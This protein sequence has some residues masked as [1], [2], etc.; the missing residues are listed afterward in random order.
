M[1]NRRTNQTRRSLLLVVLVLAM[2]FATV[3]VH[4]ATQT[5]RKKVAVVLSG[6]GA[7]G[8][9]HIGVLRVLERAGIPVDIVTGTS[10]G[11]IVGGLY[12]IGYDANHIDSLV[13]QQDWKFLLS[14][15]AEAHSPL[16]YNRER[17][18]TYLA[19]KLF[20]FQ[21]KKITSDIG[22]V[23]EGRNLGLLFNRLTAAYPD[24][25]DF[26]LLPRPFACVAT[27][28][29][30]NTE[31]VFHSGRLAEAMRSSM[32]IPGVFSPIRK[33]DRV[34]VDGGL[35]NNFP[36]DVA[37][38]MGADVVIGVT[39]Q[40][41]PKTADDIRGAADVL[42][43]IVDVNC[44]NKYDDNLAMTDVAIR[45]NTKG[46]SSA[47]FTPVA[48]DSLIRRGET[49]ALLKW[50]DIVALRQKIGID[51]TFVPEK[52]TLKV[53]VTSADSLSTTSETTHPNMVLASLG[54]RF[55]TE[56][57]VAV[58]LNGYYT[59]KNSLWNLG[60]TLRLGKRI[61]ARGDVEY[62]P[63]KKGGMRF[64]YIFRR[65]DINLYNEG[66][67][68][69]NVLYNQHTIDLAPFNFDIRN[70]AV[71]IGARFDYYSYE[72]FLSNNYRNNVELTDSHERLI[73]YYATVNYNSENKWLFPTR[74]ARFSARY[75]YN[76]DDFVKYNDK[77]GFSEIAASWR[78]AVPINSRLTLQPMV[79]GRLM[80][81]SEIPACS[82]NV[83]GGNTFSHYIEQQMPFA[84]VG[85]AEYV[86]KFTT[87]LQLLTYQRIADNNYISWNVSAFGNSD[88]LR[89]VYTSMPYFGFQLGYTY[90]SMF[91][92][93][94]ASV[95]WSTLT[96][97]PNLYI[98]LGFDF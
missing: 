70:F 98:S 77:N 80:F 68:A 59:P 20:T 33:G 9:A 66:D 39:V 76:T 48:I 44:K 29:I 10:M 4:A 79:Y 46:Y 73:A 81:G 31:Y 15:K 84:G 56:E 58:Q 38:A 97:K 25:T 87:G 3:S 49:A 65:N 95:G 23:I 55:D 21:S 16:L 43:Q 47:S 64:S 71:S 67:R 45:V 37:R 75:S 13:R 72:E 53:V 26:N 5:E 82:A 28:I 30:T 6:G 1:Q 92:P 42:S 88:E 41:A 83:V 74:G 85:Y 62:K 22:G 96:H 52:P 91:G 69:Y 35:R 7:K 86:R 2:F 36:V 24:S 51:S 27:D 50:D 11:S 40:G 17:Q 34:L 19:S 94:G 57:I 14:D 63:L 60:A 61:M 93:L 54:L 78:I 18:N 90:T 8:M 89:Y 12:A 32:A